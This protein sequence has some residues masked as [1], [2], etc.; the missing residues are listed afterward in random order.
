MKLSLIVPVYREG[1]ALGDFLHSLSAQLD[2]ELGS[3]AWQLIVVSAVE[4]DDEP[5]AVST[6]RAGKTD[7]DTAAASSS[8]TANSASQSQ[9][10]LSV[11]APKGRAR[12]MNAGAA[13]AEFELLLFLHADTVL[14]SGAFSELCAIAEAANEENF[15]GFSAL[16]L[17][18]RA[19]PF[20]IIERMISLR[21]RLS[22]VATGDQGLFLKRSLFK[23]LGG[24][25]DI[26]L[27]EDVELSKRLRKIAAPKILSQPLLTSS[28]RWETNGIASTVMLMW[29]LRLAYF[30]GASPAALARQYYPSHS[31]PS[32]AEESTQLVM[33]AKAPVLGQVKT[34]MSPA[35]SST[36]CLDL[37]RDL[38]R[39]TWGQLEQ[40]AQGLKLDVSLWASA[41][42]PEFE[43]LQSDYCLQQGR[44]LGERMAHCARHYLIDQP[45]G[46]SRAE[47]LILVGADC[48]FVDAA[49]VIEVL[50]ALDEAP[51]VFVPALDGG[52]VLLSMREYRP[53]LFS[54]ISWGSANVLAES[55]E[56]LESK[57]CDYR[58]L[59]AQTDIDEPVDLAALDGVCGLSHWAELKV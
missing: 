45:E 37:H 42:D 12:Q 48:P 25:A 24:Y 32:V 36:Q 57:A 39:H 22:R 44:G 49:L 34:R 41:A 15:W 56:A 55:C 59:T 58:L 1:T 13:L 9:P 17:S 40:S 31:N 26:P 19:W 21:S 50:A 43:A 11:S 18:G 33:F 4:G 30:F 3:G 10:W 23:A 2:R 16:R 29:R 5:V 53:E 20:R 28:R 47:K 14:P 38:M 52:Y 51:V 27:M 46:E 7:S 54:D 6:T 8:S 35:L